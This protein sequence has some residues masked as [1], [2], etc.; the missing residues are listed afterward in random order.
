MTT[1]KTAQTLALIV[2]AEARI[3]GMIAENQH[4]MLCDNCIS[5]GEEEFNIEAGHLEQL[6]YEVIQQ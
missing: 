5:Y 3:Q 6:A 1:P 2:A 4:R